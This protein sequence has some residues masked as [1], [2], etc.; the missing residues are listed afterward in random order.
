MDKQ[1]WTVQRRLKVCGFWYITV[2]GRRVIFRAASMSSVH[3][4]VG[5]RP[6][7]CSYLRCHVGGVRW[8]IW[9]LPK[10]RLLRCC[11]RCNAMMADTALNKRLQLLIC[12]ATMERL[13]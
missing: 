13:G 3:I 12:V 8:L 5:S 1:K 11:L 9:K 4:D 2:G 7:P 6:R 10:V